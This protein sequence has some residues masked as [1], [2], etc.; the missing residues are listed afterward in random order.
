[1]SQGGA[2]Q[3]GDR[4]WALLPSH[5]PGAADPGAGSFPALASVVPVA[6]SAALAGPR[7]ATE[8]ILGWVQDRSF[9]EIL[10]SDPET[11]ALS[12]A[13]SSVALPL[14]AA[15]SRFPTAFW[16]LSGI[17]AGGANI[18]AAWALASGAGTR[19]GIV[20][21]GVNR[22]HLDLADSHVGG[23]DLFA[24]GD[25]G[26]STVPGV[27]DPHGTRVAGL[28]S[29]RIDNE[30]GG[31]GVAPAAVIESTQ[32]PFSSNVNLAG[33]AA[34]LAG[35]AGF[36]VSNNSWGFT[37]AFADNF[38]SP[39]LAP[40]A[41][42]LSQAVAEGRDG[43]GTTIV[44][45][46]GNG[47]L[48]IG[49]VNVGDD[50]NFHNLTNSRHT[51]A[52]GASDA[53]GKATLFSSPGANLLLSAPGIGLMTADG[54]EIGAAGQ[55]MVAGTSFAAPLV[56]GT[57]ALMLEVNPDLG[58]R[59]IQKILA[60]TAR[61]ATPDDAPG[62]AGGGAFANA[63]RMLNGGGMVFDRDIGFGILD[64]AAAVRLA[65][66]WD[67]QST[68]QNEIRLEVV[69]GP[70]SSA[71]G[72][73][74]ELAVEVAAPDRDFALGWV[75]LSL[76]VSGA[77][78]RHMAITLESPSGTLTRIAPNLQQ[79]GSKTVLNFT[80]SS[81]ATWGEEAAGLW[82][83]VL[84]HPA[85]S[86]GFAVHEARLAL[87]GDHEGDSGHDGGAQ[88]FNRGYAAQALA[89]P[90]RK[91]IAQQG[92]MPGALV[93]AALDT[94]VVVDLAARQG[95][96]DGVDFTL[97]GSFAT[98]VGGASAD[99][100]R[101]SAFA[102][103][104]SGGA[105]GDLIFGG[106]GDDDLRGEGGADTLEGGRGQ[107][108]LRGGGSADLLFGGAHADTLYGH[109]GNDTLHGD[110]GDDLIYGMT[111]RDLI[112]G[113][114]GAD[115]IYGGEGSDTID[116]GSG[117]DT[118]YGGA[119]RD[120]IFGGSGADL[121]Y[122]GD[123]DDTIDAGSGADTV[124][125]GT[126]ND[127]IHG[128]SGADRLYGGASNDTIFGGSANDTIYGGD[129][130]DII[131]AGTGADWVYGGAGSDNFVFSTR[132]TA[133]NYSRLPDYSPYEDLLILSHAIFATGRSELQFET[134]LAAQTTAPTL[135][136][137]AASGVLEWDFDGS[138]T[139]AP[140]RMAILQPG[141]PLTAADIIL[142]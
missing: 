134:G 51:I 56:T 88:Y 130:D 60:L 83:I 31:M 90:A 45:A 105:G 125:G 127:L 19:I 92:A 136:W 10:E 61:A 42:A 106:D 71:D 8:E 72:L 128:N 85:P 7:Q 80:F 102:D 139:G 15:D 69:A 81:V 12:I 67:R 108:V 2:G 137:H 36:D 96:L 62:P 103:S 24:A 1:M 111:G 79:L 16:W 121:I 13:A 99:V 126:G 70:A 48:M 74:Y 44:F 122:G 41:A 26:T 23:L 40:L 109:S 113:G 35:Q 21:S 43:L 29:G 59:D 135:L 141:L 39:A 54:L 53:A 110:S 140:I 94:P 75:E 101:G 82:R 116:A 34:A 63:A 30:I 89:D 18:A 87:H 64:A 131:D 5:L 133:T 20:D 4:A 49:G 73:R 104:L 132:P 114:T 112:F 65:A 138:G 86:A 68:V 57:V 129:G 124:Y 52:V 17:H 84:T 38:R 91:V 32:I 123:G 55:A 33:V 119:D 58:Y 11:Q 100:L 66:V 14:A 50:S 120:L 25:T 28:V 107:D 46:G 97:E 76:S 47:R 93:F 6:P 78:L 77:Q 117:A 118:V 9:A 27:D 95:R 3:T 142:I 37:R 98:V 115:F 22:Y